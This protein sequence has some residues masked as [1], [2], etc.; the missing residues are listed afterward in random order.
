MMGIAMLPNFDALEVSASRP[1]MRESPS[2]VKEKNLHIAIRGLEKNVRKPK[3][4]GQ[5]NCMQTP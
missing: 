3:T 2:K 4:N 5:Q 1:R